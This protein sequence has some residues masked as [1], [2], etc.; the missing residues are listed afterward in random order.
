MKKGTALTLLICFCTLLG[1]FASPERRSQL[2]SLPANSNGVIQLKGASFELLT[3]TP[4]DYA[5]VVLLTA[6]GPEFGCS[7]CGHFDP[8]YQ[9][10]SKGWI[11]SK[12]PEQLY[13][14]QL[15]VAMGREVFLHLSVNSAPYILFYP[16]TEGSKAPG[17]E[18]PIV[19]SF[20]R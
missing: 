9:L 6:L 3:S 8:N 10:L 5:A 19:Y 20:R 15:D 14:G 17:G 11:S 2:E 1:C 4:R 7:A 16:P 13:F 12:N 18:G